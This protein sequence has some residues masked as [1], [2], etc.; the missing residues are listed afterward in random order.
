MNE[1]FV[2]I[3]IILTKIILNKTSKLQKFIEKFK[4]YKTIADFFFESYI[5]MV[6]VEKDD[7]QSSS[8]PWRKSNNFFLDGQDQAPTQM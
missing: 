6:K 4:T 7:E 1:V 2:S 3:W 8:V 5:Y